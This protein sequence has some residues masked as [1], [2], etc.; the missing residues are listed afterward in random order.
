M[1][2]DEA[3]YIA[4]RELLE[5]ILQVGNT[6]SNAFIVTLSASALRQINVSTYPENIHTTTRMF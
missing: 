1:V 3:R 4:L 2:Y 5:G 6:F